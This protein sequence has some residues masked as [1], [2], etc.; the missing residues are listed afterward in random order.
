MFLSTITGMSMFIERLKNAVKFRL[1]QRA[2]KREQN[3]FRVFCINL[4]RLV[5]APVFVKIGASDGITDDP[6]SDLLLA[7]TK[8]RGL[9]VEP[10]PYC[11]DRLR[12]NFQDSHRFS[13]EQVAIGAPAG[14]RTFYYVDAKA[15]QS[16]PNLPAWFDQIGSF[17]RNHIMKHLNGVLDPFITACKVQVCLLSD[18]LMRNGIQDIHLLHVDAEGHDY[19]VL[20]T[21]DFVKHVPLS[22]FVEH[23]HLSVVMKTELLSL[24]HEHGYSVRDCGEDYFAVNKEV[25]KRLYES[26]RS[27]RR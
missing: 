14:E 24:L 3:R 7:N 17:D 12:Q 16:I 2:R 11:F 9:L 23:K 18:V 8:W 27:H 15:I 13:F 10:T 5:S 25:N 6:C 1:L 20:K 21:L 26:V 19:E 22:I 4:P